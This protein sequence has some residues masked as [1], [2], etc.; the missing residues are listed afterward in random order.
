M[1]DGACEWDSIHCIASCPY[2]LTVDM[3]RTASGEI[4]GDIPE[5]RPGCF[6]VAFGLT[7]TLYNGAMGRVG[8]HDPEA[9]RFAFRPFED[10]D[11]PIRVRPSNLKWVA[12]P[13]GSPVK[14]Y[15]YSLYVD[16]EAAYSNLPVI[17]IQSAMMTLFQKVKF[18]FQDRTHLLEELFFQPNK[19]HV[20]D[21]LAV[22]EAAAMESNSNMTIVLFRRTRDNNPAFM[23]HQNAYQNGDS[24]VPD[25]V[26]L[27]D[28]IL[29]VGKEMTFDTKGRELEQNDILRH[30]TKLLCPEL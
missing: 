15:L 21:A 2:M 26:G 14:N 3:I 19:T 25:G 12:K 9:G 28:Y 7:N 16:Y 17:D 18:P 4:K 30:V 23:A 24:S 10:E 6:A 5:L 13:D 1:Q 11:H 20:C 8:K 22:F 27:K 29:I